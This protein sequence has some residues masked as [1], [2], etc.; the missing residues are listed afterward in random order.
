VFLFRKRKEEK[1][2]STIF[3]FQILGVLVYTI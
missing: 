3:I 1:Q 2:Q